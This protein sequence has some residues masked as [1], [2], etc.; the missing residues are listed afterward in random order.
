MGRTVKNIK[1]IFFL[2][3]I[4]L[5]VVLTLHYLPYKNSAEV[6]VTKSGPYIGVHSLQ[7]LGY[8]G[9]GIKIAVIDTGVDYN[10]P[11]LFGLGP[12][13][14][15]I[16]GYDF[17]DNDKTPLDTN[18]HGTEVAGIIA[19]DGTLSGIAPK[20]KLLAYRVSDT[21]ESVSSDL[22]V[23]AIEQA[24]IDEAD[25]IN[26]SLGVNKTNK[27]IDDSVNKA[28]DSGIVVVTAAGNNGPG[29]G[30]I[31]SPAKNPNSIT[32]GAS[33]N[34]VTSSIVATF[35][36]A[37]KQFSVF[38]MVGTN[39]L[40]EP[41]TGKI[42]FGEYGRK[43]DLKDLDVNDSILLVERG[44]NTEGEV[45]YFS[46][47]EKNA[48]DNGAKA[49]IVYNN[50][51]GI[52]FG[53]LYHEF[54]TPDYR[55]RIPALSL[56]NEE[57][58]ILKQMAE[59]NTVGKLNVFYNPDFVVPFSSR[60]PVSPFYIK[61]DLVAP[62]AFVNTTLNNGRYNLTSGT[63]F[64][65]PHVSGTIALLLQ[66]D[67]SLTPDEIKS[68]LVTTASQVSDPYG[69]QF[70]FEVA[71]TGRINATR[72]FDASLVIMPSY[73]IF[74]LSTEKITQSQYL[75]IKSLD[76]NT[77]SPSVS[78]DGDD[79]FDFNYKLEN[80][81][82]YV[83]ISIVEQVFGEYEG[84]III[85]HENIRYAVPVM[86]HI[87]K[88]SLF[89]N[90]HDGK[91]DFRVTYPD[92]WS[93]AKISVTNEKTGEIE[94]TSVTPNKITTLDVSDS[95]KY[96]I[97]GKITS[98]N[99]LSDVYDII[100]VSLDE[101]KKE[102]DLFGFLDIPQKTILIIFVVTAAIALVGLKIRK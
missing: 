4:S 18:G 25:I 43:K 70:P 31:G 48:A 62:G 7:K 21:G 41:I 80:G 93:Y 76:G 2:V 71:G 17:V 35:D 19:A 90:E 67:P 66:K 64:A 34:N 11:D 49:V 51:E 78:F 99:T 39:A 32:V 24:I 86:I 46:D 16:G 61:P 27:I 75:Q 63:S 83:T 50:E 89:V 40:D 44:S 74:N 69:Q 8:S 60:G 54:N 84:K 1:I 38:P 29:L 94:T 12:D 59:N 57:G 58:L 42:V 88:G 91:L 6:F 96:W 100:D 101:N 13:G 79:V 72:A 20:A 30:T 23:K 53:E 26:I 47:K 65:A 92:E 36:A 28:V 33:Y 10:H 15:V 82:L 68:L 37:D 85:E 45:V 3:I 55:P 102:I 14:K 77:A 98:G 97:E 52:F 81:M 95:G 87:T 5:S 56:S 22:I 9:D 73:L